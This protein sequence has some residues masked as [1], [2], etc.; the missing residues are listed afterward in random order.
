MHDFPDRSAKELFQASI[1]LMK[2][3]KFRYFMLL[4]GYVPWLLLSAFLLFIPALFVMSQM[5]TAQAF[6]YKNLTEK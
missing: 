5:Y 4:L 3:Q 2:G 6:F 1:K